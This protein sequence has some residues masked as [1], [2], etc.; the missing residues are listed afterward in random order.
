MEVKKWYF[1]I[2]Y[3]LYYFSIRKTFRCILLFNERILFS[4]NGFPYSA[5]T[6]R[7]AYVSGAVY[8]AS[9]LFTVL[10][11]INVIAFTQASGTRALLTFLPAIVFFKKLLLPTESPQLLH[12]LLQTNPP[13]VDPLAPFLVFLQSAPLLGP[14][15]TNKNLP[16]PTPGLND[17]IYVFFC[18]QGPVTPFFDPN[19]NRLYTHAFAMAPSRAPYRIPSTLIPVCLYASAFLLLLWTR[20]PFLARVTVRSRAGI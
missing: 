15:L 20:E 18:K 7:G 4:P 13:L 9:A 2:Y 5:G 19:F 10:L 16:P 8:G 11:L 12:L 17:S 1:D 14:F 3:I 6:S